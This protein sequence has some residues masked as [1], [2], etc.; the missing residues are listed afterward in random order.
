ML[1]SQENKNLLFTLQKH[2]PHKIFHPKS[3]IPSI[4]VK[5]ALD[6]LSVKK[7]SNHYAFWDEGEEKNLKQTFFR[8]EIA[9]RN[10]YLFFSNDFE[11]FYSYLDE[12]LSLFNNILKEEYN[13]HPRFLTLYPAIQDND[14]FIESYELIF[15]EKSLYTN[16]LNR[17]IGKYI[18]KSL[19]NS[20]KIN[21][22]IYEEYLENK[23]LMIHNRI[24]TFPLI[25]KENP[26]EQRYIHYISLSLIVYVKVEDLI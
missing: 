20:K 9:I 25:R 10:K 14:N 4:Y 13:V 21:F 19:L 15:L 18:K 3:I 23:T 11:S 17:K 24:N 12:A 2:N 1:I 6:T 16:K 5:S 26:Y 7:F 22:E 8:K